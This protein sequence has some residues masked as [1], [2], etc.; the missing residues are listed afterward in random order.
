ML[1]LQ[2]SGPELQRAHP[3]GGGDTNPGHRIAALQVHD[4][5]YRLL[6]S[7]RGGARYKTP[8]ALHLVLLQDGLQAVDISRRDGDFHHL[9]W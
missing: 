1:G 7:G 4:I 8:N 6:G 2:S 3:R 9:S 5:G